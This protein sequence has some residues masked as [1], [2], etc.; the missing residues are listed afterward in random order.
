MYEHGKQRQHQ[1]Q[2]PLQIRNQNSDDNIDGDKI[3]KKAV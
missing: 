2:L 1:T 3:L